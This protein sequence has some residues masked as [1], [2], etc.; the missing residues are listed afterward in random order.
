MTKYQRKRNFIAKINARIKTLTSRADVSVD[1]IKAQFDDMDGVWIA[2]KTKGTI[3]IKT[4][5]FNDDL[6]AEIESL[7]PT[8]LSET[9]RATTEIK[10]SWKAAKNFIGPRP[11][12][13]SEKQIHRN[14]RANFKFTHDFNENKAK[15]YEWAEKQNKITLKSSQKYLDLK[16]ELSEFGRRWSNGDL[17]AQDRLDQLDALN[18][19]GFNDD[20]DKLLDTKV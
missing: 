7:I 15:Y 16:D 17:T 3:N 11:E 18:K 19:M 14:I 8:Y 20:L 6:I 4:D 13:P 2:D 5:Y 9:D 1:D 12:K 10:D